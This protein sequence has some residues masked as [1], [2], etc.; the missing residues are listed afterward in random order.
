[1]KSTRLFFCLILSISYCFSDPG[2]L[3][4]AQSETFDFAKQIEEVELLRKK[5]LYAE[6]ITSAQECLAAA[7]REE[8]RDWSLESLYQLSLLHYLQDDY[9]S[10]N[11]FL[12]ISLSIVRLDGNL[13]KE[14]DLL[15]LQG[16]LYWKMGQFEQAKEVL[17]RAL[18]LFESIDKRLSMAS[19]A[20]NLGNVHASDNM[21]EAAISF[22]SKGLDWARQ[23]PEDSSL[24]MRASLLSNIGESLVA[25]GKFDEAEPYLLESLEVELILNEPRDLAFSYTSLGNI[26]SATGKPALAEE[27]HRKALEIQMQLND[28]WACT[29]TRIRLADALLLSSRPYEAIAVLTEGFDDARRLRSDSMLAD[30]SQTF[31]NAYLTIGDDAVAAYYQDIAKWFKERHES[32]NVLPSSLQSARNELS[33]DAQPSSP[34]YLARWGSIAILGLVIALLLFE[35]GRLRRINRNES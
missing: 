34:L 15:N 33:A 9:E 35:N 20:N 16:N 31:K 28:Q 6:A 8:A 23:I 7:E 32:E 21:H 4:S 19:V 25:L 12:E 11:T 2:Y 10:A 26:Y 30:Y 18:T 17:K 5:G 3:F 27:Y 24:R 13:Q 29:I 1:M 22:F 14:A